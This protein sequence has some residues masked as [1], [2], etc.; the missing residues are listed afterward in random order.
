MKKES[1]RP[2]IPPISTK[3]TIACHLKSLNT[4]IATKYVDVNA[5]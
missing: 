1:A 4:N 2:T 3:R 5:L